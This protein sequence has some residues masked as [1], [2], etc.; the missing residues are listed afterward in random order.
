M[1]FCGVRGPF[2]SNSMNKMFTNT[3]YGDTH[4]VY[5]YCN[6][7]ARAAVE[8]YWQQ[9]LNQRTPSRHVFI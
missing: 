2:V 5:G 3:E 9:F 8:E 7:N 1:K 6:G 4:F